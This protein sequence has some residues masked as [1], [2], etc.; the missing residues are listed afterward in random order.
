MA[1]LRTYQLGPNSELSQRLLN[2]VA[3]AKLCLL[4]PMRKAE[5]D[6]SLRDPPLPDEDAVC[7][8]PVPLGYQNSQNSHGTVTGFQVV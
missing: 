8:D 3:T 6:Q 1:H 5:Y 2:E 7:A 4:D